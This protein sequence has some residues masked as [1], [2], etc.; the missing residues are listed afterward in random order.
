MAKNRIYPPVIKHGNWKSTRNGAF[1]RKITP[2]KSCIFQHAMPFLI[3]I[4]NH[5]A[6]NFWWVKN[7]GSSPEI[8][9]VGP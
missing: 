9:M 7:T 4:S 6:G 8:P 1:N 3:G 2:H 5:P